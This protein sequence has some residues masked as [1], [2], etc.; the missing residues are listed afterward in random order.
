M[1]PHCYNRK[2]FTGYWARA[3]YRGF[4]PVLRW[5]E[6][7]MSQECKAYSVPDGTVPVPV[8]EGWRCDGCRLDPR[9]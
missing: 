8:R 9:V 6:H 1:T 5:I 3:G 7:R 4:K 2:P